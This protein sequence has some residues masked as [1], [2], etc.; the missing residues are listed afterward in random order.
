[1][2]IARIVITVIL[3]ATLILSLSVS[4]LAASENESLFIYGIN[5]LYQG[6]A[7]LPSS[8]QEVTYYD[9][10]TS[11]GVYQFIIPST[12]MQD[13]L[14]YNAKSLNILGNTNSIELWNQ[15]YI[16]T[17]YYE[18][19]I[20]NAS[21]PETTAVT[22][23]FG[24]ASLGEGD[25]ISKF[26]D[27]G[28]VIYTYNV[29]SSFTTY[30]VTSTV[31]VDENFNGGN[32]GNLSDSFTS[33]EMSIFEQGTVNISVRLSNV[34]VQKAIGEDAYYQAS[35]DAL[36][37]LN[38][39]VS[40]VDSSVNQVNNSVNELNQSVE[41]LPEA[42]V[43]AEHEFIYNSMPDAEGDIDVIKGDILAI[44]SVYDTDIQQLYYALNNQQARPVLYLPEVEIPFLDIHLWDSQFFYVDAYLNSMNSQIME[45]INIVVIFIRIIAIAAFATVGLYRMSRVEWWY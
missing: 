13:Q 16:Y 24:V 38:S 32:V 3:T 35:V 30:Y 5:C 44:L 36:N 37:D 7:G 6:S 45:Y 21:V 31:Y 33:L 26:Q 34:K 29:A 20:N 2:R 19:R 40:R 25:Y 8:Y 15:G 39:S 10:P 41:A 4:T 22:F 42:T 9:D 11:V 18:I 27:L 12:I 14:E 43:N 17:F 1:M 23:T 28:D